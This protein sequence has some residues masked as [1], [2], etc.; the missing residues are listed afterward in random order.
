MRKNVVASILTACFPYNPSN[1]Q[2]SET[3]NTQQIERNKE[4]KK[5]SIS[6][7]DMAGAFGKVSG[8]GL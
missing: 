5:S 8:N 6:P 1:C 7:H 4:Y 2:C 3:A